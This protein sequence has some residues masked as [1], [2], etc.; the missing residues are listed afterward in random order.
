VVELVYSPPW[1]TDWL[2]PEAKEKLRSYGIAPPGGP[3]NDLVSIGTRENTP[4]P[5]CGS[6]NTS[7]RSEFGSTACKSLLFCNG[8]LQ[9]FEHFKPF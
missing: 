9:P 7:L 6:K 3:S 8:C 1:T 4:C 5:Y 2:S